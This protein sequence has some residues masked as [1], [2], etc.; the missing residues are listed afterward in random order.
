MYNE[1]LLLMQFINFSFQLQQLIFYFSIQLHLILFILKISLISFFQLSPLLLL[2][3]F[4]L[5]LILDFLLYSIISLIILISLLFKFMEIQS[6]KYYQ[7]FSLFI[8]QEVCVQ[9]NLLIFHFIVYPILYVIPR[10]IFQLVDIFIFLSLYLYSSKFPSL[11]SIYSK[12]S[13]AYIS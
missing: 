3:L 7:K 2:Q 8:K 11:Q 5:Y 9:T 13:S 10:R 1:I 6:Q 12:L 4:L